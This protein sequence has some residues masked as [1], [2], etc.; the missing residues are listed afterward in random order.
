MTQKRANR[1]EAQHSHGYP[2]TV[3]YR[4]DVQ[5][6]PCE[7]MASRLPS[8]TGASVEYRYTSV[9]HASLPV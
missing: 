2:H 7:K 5:P 4:Y 6:A 8:V 3:R 9:E 1:A